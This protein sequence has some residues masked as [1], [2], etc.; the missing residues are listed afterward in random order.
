MLICEKVQVGIS[1][2]FKCHRMTLAQCGGAKQHGKCESS[3]AAC[4]DAEAV[5]SHRMS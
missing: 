3:T 5:L 2:H 1:L 4:S